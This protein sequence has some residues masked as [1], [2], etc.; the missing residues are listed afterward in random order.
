M[1]TSSPL[2]Q[3]RLLKLLATGKYNVDEIALRL[4]VKRS[5]ALVAL[6]V[7]RHEGDHVPLRSEPLGHR[8]RGQRGRPRLR[9]WIAA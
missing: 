6:S 9:Y 8:Q 5:T 7:L 4:G 3:E 1:S 2:V